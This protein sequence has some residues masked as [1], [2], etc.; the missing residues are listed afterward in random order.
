MWDYNVYCSHFI[1]G[2]DNLHNNNEKVLKPDN[3]AE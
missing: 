2:M 1:A 3:L